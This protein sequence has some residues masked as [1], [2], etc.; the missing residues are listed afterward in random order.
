[1]DLIVPFVRKS[2]ESPQKGW[3]IFKKSNEDKK[4]SE[5]S[6]LEEGLEMRDSEKKNV[7]LLLEQQ[8]VACALPL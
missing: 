2:T 3:R 6:R 1:M 5:K 4:E 7:R 8:L